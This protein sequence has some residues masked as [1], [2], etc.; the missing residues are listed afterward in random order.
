MKKIVL[1]LIGLLF[2]VS[3]SNAQTVSTVE[4]SISIKKTA[5]FKFKSQLYGFLLDGTYL[6]NE[7]EEGGKLVVEVYFTGKARDS[8]YNRDGY[9]AYV[10]RIAIDPEELSFVGSACGTKYLPAKTPVDATTE[11]ST[12]LLKKIFS[13]SDKYVEVP[14]TKPYKF[15]VSMGN[16]YCYVTVKLN[17][18]KKYYTYGFKFA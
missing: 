12:N 15:S 13:K 10:V 18:G 1:N 5:T 3:F 11:H 14:K 16:E 4:D 6:V 17:S 8:Y 7:K 9:N 2:L